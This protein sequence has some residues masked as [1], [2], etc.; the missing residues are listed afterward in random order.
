MQKAEN[1]DRERVPFGIRRWF[2]KSAVAVVLL[3][4]LGGCGTIF[5]LAGPIEG[6]REDFG[7]MNIYGGV[8]LDAK[9]VSEARGAWMTSL[10]V[11]A[12]F[13]EMPLSFVLDTVT[14]P[15]TIPVTLSR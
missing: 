7:Q 8:R 1:T 4:C 15:V 11:L 10:T 13:I 6:G 9:A 14:L 12:M 2:V 5:N 3:C